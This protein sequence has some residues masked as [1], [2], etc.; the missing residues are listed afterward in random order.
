[1]KIVNKNCQKCNN[2]SIHPVIVNTIGTPQ[3]QERPSNKN[4]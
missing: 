2:N 1:M 3:K 4:V